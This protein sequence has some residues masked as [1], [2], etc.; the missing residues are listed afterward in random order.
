MK[1]YAVKKAG[2]NF[3]PKVY[4]SWAECK[5]VV[6]GAKGAVYK[7]FT[8]IEDAYA[9]INEREEV[10]GFDE[11][12]IL[13]AYVDGSY[14]E[15]ENVAGYGVAFV[16]NDKVICEMKKTLRDEE[17]LKFNNI[18]GE[19]KG[20]EDAVRTAI[21]NGCK[22]VNLVYDCAGIGNW[23]LGNW[24][25]NNKLSSDYIKAMSYYKTR[26]KINFIKVKAHAKEADG[27]HKYNEL[28]DKLAKE[29]VGITI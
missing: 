27:G 29:A 25:A 24:E 14:N 19:V 13:Y 9:Y 17:F 28:A 7:S 15:A 3:E 21:K 18:Y 6:I 4:T 8:N 5:E 22:E 11:P 23:A 1:Y 16:F 2:E 20:A 26:I 10:R 12:N